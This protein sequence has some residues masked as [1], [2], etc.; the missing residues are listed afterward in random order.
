MTTPAT[1]PEQVRAARDAR[2]LS[3]VELAEASGVPQP[4]IAHLEHRGA[5]VTWATLARL[6]V[7]LG[8]SLVIDPEAPAPTVRLSERGKRYRARQRE[9][10]LKNQ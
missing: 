4:T 6:A 10:F 2:G 8:V 5:N 1:I 9:S 7:A 3:Q